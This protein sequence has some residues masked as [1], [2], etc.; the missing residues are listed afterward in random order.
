MTVE[1]VESLSTYFPL[2]FPIPTPA[3]HPN[4][5]STADLHREEDLLRNP[6]SFRAWWSAIN[7]AREAW[8]ATQKTERALNLPAHLTTLLGPLATPLSRASLQRLTFLYESAL[9]QFPGSFKLWKAYLQMRMGFVLGNL[10]VKKRAGGRKKFPAMKD[11]LGEEKEDHMEKWEG[12]LNGIVGWEEWK[13]LVVTFE[14]ALMWLPKVRHKTLEVPSH[15]VA[16]YLRTNNSFPAYGLCTYPFSTIRNVLHF[17]RTRTHEEPT[18]APCAPSL[19]PST[20]A[21][22][23]AIFSG[24]RPEGVL[25]SCLSTTGI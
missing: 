22:G 4:L 24:L 15:S 14:R 5:I 8:N 1:N 11:A 23:S 13:S 20:P 25:R 3:T 18:I 2:T 7:I 21:F 16:N 19:L 9:A 6:S 10:V 12:G 17:S